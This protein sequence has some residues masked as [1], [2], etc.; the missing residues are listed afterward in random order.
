MK[1]IE[2]Q[3]MKCVKIGDK[4]DVTGIKQTENGEE[5]HVIEKAGNLS[6]E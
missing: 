6:S 5:L 1:N 2:W 3:T 4:F